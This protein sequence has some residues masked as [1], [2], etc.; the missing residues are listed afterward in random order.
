M[1]AIYFH[2][3]SF[4]IIQFELLRISS[5]LRKRELFFIQSITRNYVVFVWIMLMIRMC[6]VIS[7]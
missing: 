3:I 6:C 4:L 7:L 1:F 2:C 5:L